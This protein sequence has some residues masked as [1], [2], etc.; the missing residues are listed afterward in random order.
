[1]PL[2]KTLKET[3]HCVGV[4]SCWRHWACF[5]KRSI[6]YTW[7][8]LWTPN[9]YSAKKFTDDCSVSSDFMARD[10]SFPW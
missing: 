2:D 8:R 1:V 7:K 4:S 10:H 3:A 9:H 5:Q 6:L